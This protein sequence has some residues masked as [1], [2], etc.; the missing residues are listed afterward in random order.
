MAPDNG[1]ERA[2]DGA[3]SALG[4]NGAID[5]LRLL[6]TSWAIKRLAFGSDLSIS[7]WCH[8]PSS[9]SNG[10]ASRAKGDGGRGKRIKI[11]EAFKAKENKRRPS[12]KTRA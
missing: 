10:V 3:S 1:K 2:P 9:D 7:F 4:G 8:R 12:R 11:F 5:D 6:R